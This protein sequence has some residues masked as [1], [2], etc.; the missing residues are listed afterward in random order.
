MS[1]EDLT[2][3]FVAVGWLIAAIAFSACGG[4]SEPPPSAEDAVKATVDA[5]NEGILSGEG[6]QVCSNL[7]TKGKRE[8]TDRSRGPTSCAH[9]AADVH[10]AFIGPPSKL[11]VTRVSVHRDHARAQAVTVAPHQHGEVQYTLVKSGGTWKID[12]VL[13]SS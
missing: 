7:T 11:T 3:R 13:G 4:G 2:T 8:M 10:K 12:F 6:A 9:A 5:Y 1:G